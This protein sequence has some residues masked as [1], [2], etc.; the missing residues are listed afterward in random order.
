MM[1]NRKGSHRQEPRAD[2]PSP[3]KTPGGKVSGESVLNV[4]AALPGW[5]H[6]N[7]NQVMA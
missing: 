3:H 4:V 2:F 1:Q 5:I 7:V 6:D